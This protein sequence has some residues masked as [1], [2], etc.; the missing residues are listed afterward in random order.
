MYPTQ[1]ALAFSDNMMGSLPLYGFFR[2]LHFDIQT[3][4][5]LWWI[6]VCILNYLC[7]FHVL[8]KWCRNP[9]LAACAA[10]IFAFGLFN[11]SQMSYLQMNT[12]FMVPFVFWFTWQLFTQ[13]K[14]T[15]WIKLLI[16]LVVQFYLS[17]Y[18]GFLVFYSALLF[19]VILYFIYKPTLFSKA[20]FKKSHLFK[21]ALPASLALG[22]LF[23]LLLPYYK[24]SAIT[25]LRLYNEV[26]PSLAKTSSYFFA[27][28]SSMTWQFLSSLGK[29][30]NESW[31][32][33][34][35]MCGMIPVLAFLVAGGLLV[36]QRAK[37]KPLDKSILIVFLTSF[38]LL[39][40]FTRTSGGLSLYALVFKLPGM[41]SM[42]VL[43]RFM[44]V[45]LFL[46]LLLFVLVLNKINIRNYQPLL[47]C[48]VFLL[49][50]GDNLFDHQ[51]T[52]R[53][54]KQEIQSRH[55]LLQQELAKRLNGQKTF[56]VTIRQGNACFT[57]LDAM[58]AGLAL[59]IP[60]VNGYSSYC[61]NDFGEFFRTGS[62]EGLT[63]W[64]TR[65]KINLSE[66]LIVKN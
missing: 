16:C 19:A 17:I 43:T 33:Q 21:T 48:L 45:E 66:V 63:F 25:G 40:L 65:K 53:S 18:L 35:I 2:V 6:S 12:R 11:Q 9:Y 23:I 22:L 38:I 24:I 13:P 47:Y 28:E 62:E 44:H 39:I 32:L 55:H 60:T 52:L 51:K 46:L 8:H 50:W 37:R 49:V 59:G 30:Q 29:V 41:N 27:H 20:S 15:Y 58:Y 61:E 14:Y 34:N 4:Y 1:N 42:R 56:A 36:L 54:S 7:C 5:Q 31:W 3:A 64:T 10:F 26:V 57:H